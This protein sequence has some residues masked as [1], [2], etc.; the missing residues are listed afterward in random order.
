MCPLDYTERSLATYLRLAVPAVSA[1]GCVASVFPPNAR[2]PFC[3]CANS[4][5]RTTSRSLTARRSHRHGCHTCHSTVADRPQATLQPELTGTRY[6]AAVPYT[7]TIP[8]PR[9]S[10]LVLT[11]RPGPGM[12]DRA[13]LET[14]QTH[15][16]GSFAL[17][18]LGYV[19]IL[20]PAALL[21][22]HWKKSPLV[23]RGEARREGTLQAAMFTLPSS[24]TH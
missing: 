11:S 6:G 12:I 1:S 8:N 15:W 5:Y 7:A 3:V 2:R 4:N 24:P 23:R 17:N 22:R 16:L 14:V 10:R 9:P 20:A 13:M 18:V 19:L 21:I